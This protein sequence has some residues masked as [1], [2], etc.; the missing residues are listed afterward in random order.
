MRQ[1]LM[2]ALAAACLV[3]IHSSAQAP[4]NPTK[5]D[6][7]RDVQ[8]IFQQHCYECHGAD[9]QM[10]GLRLDRRHEAMRGGTV[11]VIGRGSSAS[12]RLYLRLIGTQFGE[13]MP[14]DGH[15]TPDQIET[16]KAWIDQGAEWPDAAAGDP[17]RLPTDRDATAAI[18]AV[19]AGNRSALAKLVAANPAALNRRG[20]GGSTPLMYA[21]LVEDREAVRLMLE[22]G[23]NPNVQ[24]DANATALMWAVADL[25]NT[26][27]LIDAG[28][29]V[30]ARSSDGRTPLMIAASRRG[31]APVLKLLLDRGARANVSG[32]W[33]AGSITPL[34]EAALAGD[35]DMIALLLER[36]AKLTAP[37]PIG[38]AMRARC[39]RCVGL[40]L[41]DAPKDLLSGVMAMGGPPLGPA[42]ATIPMLHAGADPNVLHPSGL[43]ML[44]LTAAS[45]AQPVDA[46]RAL[47]ERGL[48]VNAEG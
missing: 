14:K 48:D 1:S 46:A 12:S 18:D 22:A 21:A 37:T 4:A 3:S 28:A 47:I 24:N 19:R 32:P 2:A 36:G 38:L 6:F 39:D 13:R 31:S 8:P 11:A 33:V 17:P 5:I 40:L 45:D 42:L 25:E 29:D 34:G 44:M 26:Q 16:I 23:A 15:L 30:N 7:V 43:N 10:N 41:K 27:R 35:A 9:K 20:P